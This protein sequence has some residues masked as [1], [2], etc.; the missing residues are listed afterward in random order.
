M[1]ALTSRKVLLWGGDLSMKL[2]KQF[3]LTAP[4]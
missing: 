1:D 4:T 3:Y 2:T